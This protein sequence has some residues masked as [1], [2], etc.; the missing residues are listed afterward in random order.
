MPTALETCQRFSAFRGGN[1]GKAIGQA[2]TDL[3]Q[4]EVRLSAFDT[5]NTASCQNTSCG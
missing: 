5:W 3:V 1:R 2:L 4:T